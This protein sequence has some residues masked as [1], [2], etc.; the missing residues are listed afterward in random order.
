M[1]SKTIKNLTTF[2]GLAM[3]VFVLTSC[4]R[5]GYGCPYEMEAAA[6][7]LQELIK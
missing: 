1:S 7:V 3:F 2:L 5:G 4:N 6:N